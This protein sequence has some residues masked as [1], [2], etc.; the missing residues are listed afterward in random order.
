VKLLFK[1]IRKKVDS[2]AEL[3]NAHIIVGLVCITS[4]NVRKICRPCYMTLQ[5]PSLEKA[6]TDRYK[7]PEDKCRKVLSFKK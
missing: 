4:T 5:Q 6:I 3:L 7:L 1:S 2:R